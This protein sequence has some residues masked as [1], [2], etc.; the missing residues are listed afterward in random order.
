MSDNIKIDVSKDKLTATIRIFGFEQPAREEILKALEESRVVYGIY[1]DVVDLCSLVK[2]NDI[3]IIAS[4]DPPVPGRNGSVEIMWE[5]GEAPEPHGIG[6]EIVDFRETSKLIS[7]NEGVLLAQRHPPVNGEAGKAVTGE[8]ILP[9]APREAR[10]VAGKGVRLDAGED[11]A[12][13]TVQGRPVAKRSGTA[14][15]IIVE[16][17]Y[18]VSGDVSIKTGNI[19]FKGDVI[20]P[21]NILETMTVEASGNVKV[22]GIV[23]GANVFCGGSLAVQKNVIGSNI[24]AGIGALECGKIKYLVNDVY[25]DLNS[26]VE[27]LDQ[28]KGKM[29]NIE[30]FTFSQLINGLIE[31]RFKNIRVIAR[32]LA[33]AKT[34]NLPFE[35]ADA[36][37]S[38]R[39][40]AGVQFTQE[41]FNEM[42]H[43][44]KQALEVMGTQ[45]SQRAMV[46]M[47][48]AHGSSIN[49][50][51]EVAVTGKGCVNT[52]IYAGGS[53]KIAGSFKGGEIYS[54]GNVE[55]DEL[56]S[57][58]GAPPLVRVKSKNMVKINRT[59]PGSVIQVGSN[60]IN[61]T[62]EIGP[63]RYRLTAEG[64]SIEIV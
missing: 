3:M 53:V 12:Y 17:T 19:R 54:E 28:L 24:T 34:F 42:M 16:P 8:A 57:N 52:T 15:L 1:Q 23:T 59:L 14:L 20:V 18:T 4:G 61:V 31:N 13:S 25:N 27:L 46:I 44:L 2:V 35:V 48:S 5:K 36:L 29:A 6:A 32:Q 9:P 51:G 45:E 33:A 49:C 55:I 30:K 11:R 63:A 22:S 58:L 64:D 41:D 7:V 21:G 38:I 39:I 26:M 43:N 62:M 47:N 40:I 60:R 37:E 56:G 10:I 50:S